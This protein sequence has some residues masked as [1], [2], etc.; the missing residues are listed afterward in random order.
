MNN[1]AYKRQF[2]MYKCSGVPTLTNL[3]NP[4]AQVFI[5]FKSFFFFKCWNTLLCTQTT[6]E[7]QLVEDVQYP[8]S[9]FGLNFQSPVDVTETE[10]RTTLATLLT[11]L[12]GS[13]S[14][15]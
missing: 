11:S 6:Y 2:L 10:F 7:V 9:C 12:G 1:I 13:V 3:A 15:N 14:T 4:N 5:A 8:T